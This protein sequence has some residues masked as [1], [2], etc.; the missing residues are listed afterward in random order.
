MPF[1]KR[2]VWHADVRRAAMVS[3]P[4]F[5]KEFRRQ[6]EAPPGGPVDDAATL[7]EELLNA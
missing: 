3:R 6:R 5:E 7:R 1:L 4:E 2:P